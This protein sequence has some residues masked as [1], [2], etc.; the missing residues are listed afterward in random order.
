MN[1]DVSFVGSGVFGKIY[2][3]KQGKKT[4]AFKI[5]SKKEHFLHAL[6]YNTVNCK[7][8]IVKPLRVA[9]SDRKIIHQKAK[10]KKYGYPIEYLDG[11]SLIDFVNDSK[12]PRQDKLV[13]REQIRKA[14]LCLWSH[15]FIHGDL[16]PGNIMVVY[17]R[18]KPVAKII[19]FGLA[20]LYE[21]PKKT[22]DKSEWFKNKWKEHLKYAK[23]SVGN[24]N[25]LFIDPE[26]VTN[27]YISKDFPRK[28][29]RL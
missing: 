8:F 14:I 21:K 11:R 20:Y 29:F 1:I 27:V 23:Q 26:I 10:E 24:P 13:V 22:Q 15:G 3:V 9:L 17:K 4:F 28:L 16:H 2:K 5:S 25:S 18:K 19:D 7:R 12:V 6:I